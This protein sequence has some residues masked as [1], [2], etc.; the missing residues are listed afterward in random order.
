MEKEAT[1]LAHRDEGV[2]ARP[3]ERFAGNQDGRDVPALRDREVAIV[4]SGTASDGAVGIREV[5]ANGGITIAQS[6]DSAKFDGMPRAA[7]ATG[8]IDLALTPTQI[9]EELREI[10]RHPYSR[11]YERG[12]THGVGDA[13]L[14]RIFELLRPVSGVDFGHYKQPTIRRRLLR[15]GMWRCTANS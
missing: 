7:I 1:P 8:M 10:T 6:P 3:F 11:K 4:L 14:R 5:K 15:N 9:G 13:D 2:E 12:E